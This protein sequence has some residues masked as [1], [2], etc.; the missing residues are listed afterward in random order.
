MF[1]WTCS[2]FIYETIGLTAPPL[3]YDLYH[4]S[5]C[6]LWIICHR[7]FITSFSCIQFHI[8]GLCLFH[9]SPLF[10]RLSR[11]ISAGL[12]WITIL[13]VLL[14]WTVIRTIT[15]RKR[16]GWNITTLLGWLSF[17]FPLAFSSFF[18]WLWCKETTRVTKSGQDGREV[19][20]NVCWSGNSGFS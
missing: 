20:R 14:I 12:V 17:F 9:P 3:I 7:K 13:L 4:V 18:F 2:L 16:G 19:L 10:K 5:W 11:S 15:W 8:P 1:C 6:K